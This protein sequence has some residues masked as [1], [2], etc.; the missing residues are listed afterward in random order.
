MQNI[1]EESAQ[2]LETGVEK[3]ITTLNYAFIDRHLP[4]IITNLKQE[5]GYRRDIARRPVPMDNPV[6]IS[7]KGKRTLPSA[8]TVWQNPTWQ[9]A[10][11]AAFENNGA[12]PF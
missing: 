12:R 7:S 8:T 11:G 10:G 1:F 3:Q 5:L 9:G 6:N 2:N 4:Y